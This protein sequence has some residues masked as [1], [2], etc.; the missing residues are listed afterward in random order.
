[1]KPFYTIAYLG[2]NAFLYE[3]GDDIVCLM[4]NEGGTWIGYCPHQYYGDNAIIPDPEFN[5][6]LSC[7]DGWRDGHTIQVPLD[8]VLK[9]VFAFIVADML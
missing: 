2:G 9:D 7:H 5:N 6:K 3:V 4:N 1:M 8:D